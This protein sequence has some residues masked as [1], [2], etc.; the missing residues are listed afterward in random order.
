MISY[1]NHNESGSDLGYSLLGELYSQKL[2]RPD[3]AIEAYKNAILLDGS[4]SHYHNGLGLAYNKKKNYKL[5][6]FSF[7]EAVRVNPSDAVARYNEACMY[8]L[9]GQPQNAILSLQEA[10]ALSPSLIDVAQKDPDLDNI[11]NLQ[12]FNKVLKDV[13]TLDEDLDDA[14]AH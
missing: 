10:L 13:Q 11:R 12:A 14:L 1:I 6:L 8:S 3:E 7:K 2:N 9:L 5:A 4:K